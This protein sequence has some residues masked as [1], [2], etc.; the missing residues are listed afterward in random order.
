[1]LD[2]TLPQDKPSR[3]TLFG[4]YPEQMHKEEDG[5]GL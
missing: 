4:F 2:K 3:C 5:N 1:M